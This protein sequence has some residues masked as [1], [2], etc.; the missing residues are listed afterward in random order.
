MGGANRQKRARISLTVNS[1]PT[2]SY[3]DAEMD[4]DSDRASTQQSVRSLPTVDVAAPLSA[5]QRLVAEKRA[6]ATVCLLTLRVCLQ[7]I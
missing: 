6:V 2:S 1:N 4:D 7:S 5:L 3:D